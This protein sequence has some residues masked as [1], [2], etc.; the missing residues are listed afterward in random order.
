VA[1]ASLTA[2]G[3]AILFSYVPA[4]LGASISPFPVL[5]LSLVAA[6][7]TWLWLQSPAYTTG[8]STILPSNK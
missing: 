8:S 1:V 7:I 4:R 6:G 2:L 3:S 5:I